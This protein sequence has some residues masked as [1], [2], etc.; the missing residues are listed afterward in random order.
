MTFTTFNG[1]SRVTRVIP[2]THPPIVKLV[3]QL[4]PAYVIDFLIDELLVAGC[5]V[6]GSLEK[7]LAQTADVFPWVGSDEKIPQITSPFSRA[8][9]VLEFEQVPGRLANDVV[10]VAFEIRFLNRMT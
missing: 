6:F 5:T 10:G 2:A 7:P 9:I 1:S 8:H 4:H 3:L